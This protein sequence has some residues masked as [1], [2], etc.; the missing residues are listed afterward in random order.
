[1]A[2]FNTSGLETSSLPSSSKPIPDSDLNSNPN[3]N[4]ISD[5]EPNSGLGDG[6]DFNTGSGLGNPKMSTDSSFCPLECLPFAHFLAD[7]ASTVINEYFR[8]PISVQLKMDRSPVTIADESVERKLRQRIRETFP[9]HG[10]LGEEGGVD[11]GE[12]GSGEYVWVL[13]P[14]DGTASFISGKPLFGVLIALLHNGVPVLGVLDQPILK[15]R[16]VG[17]KTKGNSEFLTSF[18]GNPVRSRKCDSLSVA[19]IYST[20]PHLFSGESENAFNRLR[21]QVLRTGY[22]CD[23]YAFGLLALGFVDIV[24]EFGMKPWDYLA[25]VPIVEGAGG[26]FTDWEGKPLRLKSFKPEDWVGEC[27]AV[28]DPEMHKEAMAA[29]AWKN[30]KSMEGTV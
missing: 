13:D 12:G 6:T 30:G 9:D 8:I 17:V 26:I 21:K 15:E 3:P 20:S 11:F 2:S 28:G 14:I 22:G 19:H 29:L 24:V 25:L 18:N 23:C 4:P 16:W 7:E 10:I 1:M 27:L 5:P